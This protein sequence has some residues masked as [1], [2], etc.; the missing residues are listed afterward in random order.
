MLADYPPSLLMR[1][2]EA[3]KGPSY[4][5]LVNSDVKLV[6]EHVYQVVQ[7]R[8]RA[9]FEVREQLLLDVLTL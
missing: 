8:H 3:M 6:E 1:L 2:V 4:D 7:I 5:T 9:L